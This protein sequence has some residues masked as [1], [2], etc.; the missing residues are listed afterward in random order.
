ME[1]KTKII[2]RII[3]I[4][5]FIIG[6]FLCVILF[7]GCQ[8][9]RFAPL[10]GYYM[11]LLAFTVG[12]PI[13]FAAIESINLKNKSKARLLNLISHSCFLISTISVLL[14]NIIRYYKTLFWF[15]YLCFIPLVIP[16]LIIIFFT[17]P[18]VKEQFK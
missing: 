14:W 16:L 8:L 2:T 3:A 4:F 10:I 7:P 9:V 1:K 18:K 6:G 11:M 12:V 17:R 13:V 15:F 5:D